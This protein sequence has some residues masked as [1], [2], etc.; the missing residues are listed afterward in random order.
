MKFSIIVPVYNAEKYLSECIDSVLEQTYDNFEIVLINDGSVDGSAELCDLLHNQYPEKIKAVHQKNKGQLMT[1]YCGAK[2]ASGDYCVFLDS[3]DS[4]DSRC[5]EVLNETINKNSCPDTIIY[6][7]F[8]EKDGKR[9]KADFPFSDGAVFSGE[10]KTDLCG[11]FLEKSTLNNVWTKAVKREILL[12]DNVGFENYMMLRCSEDRLQVME[13]ITNSERIVCIDK[14]LYNYKLVDGSV[15]RCFSV[16]S[17]E[18]FN[19]RPL[20][21]VEEEYLG[22]WNM[23]TK[24]WQEKLEAVFLNYAMYTYSNFYKNLSSSEDK[25]RLAEYDWKNF[26]KEEYLIRMQA[27][28]CVKDEYKKLWGYVLNK[29]YFLIELHFMKKNA[30]SALKNTK[31]RL[32]G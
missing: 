4:L 24:E 22:K 18:K 26:V 2:E 5:L 25:K 20:C 19:I 27:N 32:L 8:Y 11:A 3:D 13:F 16:N 15:T 1:R 23:K 7:F 9:K 31:R 28:T 29:K 12:Q 30:Y 10:N 21:E 14:P 6:S 17:I